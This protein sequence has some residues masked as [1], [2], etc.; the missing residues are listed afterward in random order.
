MP[1]TSSPHFLLLPLPPGPT[2]SGPLDKI[3]T[4]VLQIM[5]GICTCIRGSSHAISGSI[6]AIE[7][8]SGT[9]E[10]LAEMRVCVAIELHNV[11]F[12]GTSTLLLIEA[13]LEFNC[14]AM[15]ACTYSMSVRFVLLLIMRE[16]CFAAW[17]SLA[18]NFWIL[19][20]KSLSIRNRKQLL[21]WFSRPM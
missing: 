10:F 15:K 1:I 18:S 13:G 11:F 8:K 2:R 17:C 21:T 3:R 14:I 4:A 9:S 6:A 19:G 5:D 20:G 16:N 12:C 7:I